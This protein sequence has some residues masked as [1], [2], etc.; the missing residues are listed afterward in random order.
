MATSFFSSFA[1]AED[2]QLYYDKGVRL[3]IRDLG[4]ESRTRVELQPQ[5]V[6]RKNDLESN[7]S[8]FAVKRARFLSEVS[9]LD[10]R[11]IARLSAEFSDAEKEKRDDNLKDAWIDASA[12]DLL[13]MRIGQFKVPYGR[14]FY[15]D[16][17]K[18]QTV[19]RSIASDYFSFG[20]QP[21]AMLHGKDANLYYGAAITNG[22]S[23]GEGENRPG[24]D[25]KHLG[26][27]IFG[28]GSEN[29]DRSFE[30]LFGREDDTAYAIGLS[31]AVGSESV[32]V[33]ESDFFLLGANA[34]IHLIG[35]NFIGEYFY[36]RD[37]FITA[38]NLE[39][40]G[41]YLQVGQ[42]IV[43]KLWEVASRYSVVMKDDNL[44]QTEFSSTLTR[45]IN[46]QDFKV[47]LGVSFFKIDTEVGADL[48]EQEVTLLATYV[49]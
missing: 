23:D 33:D 19:N 49:L 46:E 32:A 22:N 10:K 20:R 36:R 8:E 25:T 30:G 35:M 17:L 16:D 18:Y 31:S 28:Y 15:V 1:F 13:K 34:E 5:Y 38:E 14:Q 41:F 42:F 27:F 21:G 6:F 3:N 48:T 45:F 39:E 9:A 2:A 29:F 47:Q 37:D 4:I 44:D 40:S 12:A 7:K 26:S 43:P 24:V 11:I